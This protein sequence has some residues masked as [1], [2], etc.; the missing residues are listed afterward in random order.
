M[1]MYNSN[2]VLIGH[3]GATLEEH[4]AEGESLKIN[5]SIMLALAESKDEVIHALKQDVYYKSG[6]WDWEKVQIHPVSI[7]D[8]LQMKINIHVQ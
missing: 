4:T 6:V 5:G 8:A 2:L 7:E 3:T 1:N